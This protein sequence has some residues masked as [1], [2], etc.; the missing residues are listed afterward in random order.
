MSC[1]E[2]WPTGGMPSI[3]PDSQCCLAVFLPTSLSSSSSCFLP[4]P[5]LVYL[6]GNFTVHHV[7]R[8][9]P[10]FTCPHTVCP[11][12]MTRGCLLPTPLDP[13][14]C[15]RN[16]IWRLGQPAPK[17]LLPYTRPSDSLKFQVGSLQISFIPLQLTSL[18]PHSSHAHISRLFGLKIS[19]P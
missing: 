12:G 15:L 18:C 10:S 19:L 4:A 6:L 3:Y 14:P 16:W 7:D 11:P 13:A 5:G 2:S 8:L 1:P 9:H 17:S